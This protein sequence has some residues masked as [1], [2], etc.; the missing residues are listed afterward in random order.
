MRSILTRAG[1]AI[2]AFTAVAFGLWSALYSQASAPDYS[3]LLLFVAGLSSLAVVFA[4]AFARWVPGRM[5]L[6][7]LSAAGLGVAGTFE[8][9]LR[10]LF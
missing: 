1:Q 2:L 6:V 4:C 5:R 9:A 7:P 8:L 3:E 10:V